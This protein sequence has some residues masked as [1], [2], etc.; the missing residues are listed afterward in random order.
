MRRKLRGCFIPRSKL[1]NTSRAVTRCFKCIRRRG[2]C[3][4]PERS[5]DT[6]VKRNKRS[7]DA[8]SRSKKTSRGKP[9]LRAKPKTARRKDADA[10]DVDEASDA[11]DVDRAE[12]PAGSSAPTTRISGKFALC[13]TSLILTFDPVGSGSSSMPVTLDDVRMPPHVERPAPGSG[14]LALARMAHMP[15]FDD[16]DVSLLSDLEASRLRTLRN[17]INDNSNQI[18]LLESTQLNYRE[19]A[20]VIWREAYARNRQAKGKGRAIE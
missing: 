13:T 15:P 5:D 6:I 2:K 17:A 19:E 10:M 9:T 1:P 4:A 3:L 11:M 16:R 12:E 18:W 20:E 8:P 14:R 7:E